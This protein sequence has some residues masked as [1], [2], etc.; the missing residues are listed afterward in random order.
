MNHSHLPNDTVIRCGLVNLGGGGWNAG[1]ATI[2][3]H[4]NE[5][6]LHIA[7]IVETHTTMFDNI[8]TLGPEYSVLAR[9]RHM[10]TRDELTRGGVALV[11]A[12][13]DDASC[14]TCVTVRNDLSSEAC[15]WYHVTTTHIGVFIGVV[16]HPPG[17][18]SQCSVLGCT[19]TGCQDD[20]SHQH[21]T[22]VRRVVAL[23]AKHTPNCRIVL[24][25][26]WNACPPNVT[27][28]DVYR[29]D[30][31]RRRWDTLYDLLLSETEGDDDVGDPQFNDD[32][33]S[34]LTVCNAHN[35]D[36]AMHVTRTDS[37]RNRPRY[38]ILDLVL[39][40]PDSADAITDV[41]SHDETVG[42]HWLL[43][44]CIRVECPPTQSPP[45]RPPTQLDPRLKL[46]RTHELS[47]D[48]RKWHLH[49][50]AAYKTTMVTAKWQLYEQYV[51]SS[52]DQMHAPYLTPSICQSIEIVGLAACGL[53]TTVPSLR[54]V[55]S[56]TLTQT[57]LVNLAGDQLQRATAPSLTAQVRKHKRTIKASTAKME[58]LHQT[59]LRDA[60]TLSKIRKYE[61]NI[62]AA[63]VTLRQLYA[64]C[65]LHS[66]FMRNQHSIAANAVLIQ[67]CANRDPKTIAS[68]VSAIVHTPVLH[69]LRRNK[70][71]HMSSAA[72]K[73]Q[74][75]QWGAHLLEVYA[76]PQP[77]TA[78]LIDCSS[79]V[80]P[81]EDELLNGPVTMLE[82]RD[83][84][85][86]L[87]GTSSCYGTPVFALKQLI[88]MSTPYSTAIAN[89]FTAMLD[90]EIPIPPEYMISTITFHL[91]PGCKHLPH[92]PSS[93]RKIGMGTSIARLLQSIL[94][95][96]LLTFIQRTTALHQ[97]QG[98]FVRNNSVQTVQ[99]LL[100][101]II[102][103]CQLR[104]Q[105]LVSLFVDI[106]SAFSSASHI[107]ILNA[108][109]RVGV[110]GKIWRLLRDY[111]KGQHVTTIVG[112]EV[113][114]PILVLCGLA[115]GP[116]V[117]PVLWNV[118]FDS[119]I[120]STVADLVVIPRILTAPAAYCDDFSLLAWGPNMMTDLQQLTTRF[121]QLCTENALTLNTAPGKTEFVVF[122]SPDTSKDA[123]RSQRERATLLLG[124][125]HVGRVPSYKHLGRVL[126]GSGAHQTH[127]HQLMART[128]MVQHAVGRMSGAGMSRSLPCI[129]RLAFLTHIRPIATFS[130]ELWGW[131]TPQYKIENTQL[132]TLDEN[133]MEHTLLMLRAPIQSV[134]TL[135][136]VLP[137]VGTMHVGIIRL[138][139]TILHMPATH[140]CAQHNNALFHLHHDTTTEHLPTS[141]TWWQTVS[142]LLRDMD[143]VEQSPTTGY[144]MQTGVH[145]YDTVCKVMRCK[146]HTP[147]VCSNCK[148]DLHH[149]KA[150]YVYTLHSLH[151]TRRLQQVQDKASLTEVA[152]LLTDPAVTTGPLPFLQLRRSAANVYR[153]HVRAGSHYVLGYDYYHKRACMWC[154]TGTSSIVHLLRDCPHWTQLRTETQD[155]VA[156]EARTMGVMKPSPPGASSADDAHN[157]YLFTI[158]HAVPT[159]FMDLAVF[160][161]RQPVRD[162]KTQKLLVDKRLS[163]SDH[164]RYNRLLE[165]T[166]G[167]LKTV[168][169]TTQERLGLRRLS[170]TKDL[171][172][173]PQERVL[174]S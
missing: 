53:I 130:I 98:G 96:R 35:N 138:L 167:Y 43:T 42:D 141:R 116:A 72:D 32:G 174:L 50:D 54:R 144:Y 172:P 140:P 91:K 173:H 154:T 126:V 63:V 10:G 143:A 88:Y 33:F 89:H 127:Q 70:P 119:I 113:L 41:H 55:L 36:E 11:V 68:A 169:R 51:A 40:T 56:K 67:A 78:P 157:W 165:M 49:K 26:D 6:S 166:S 82:L 77:Q 92:A 104:R 160:Q 23:L 171:K 38:T 123:R 59:R 45:H 95:N 148:A 61:V 132:N 47:L 75:M 69:Q 44:W 153:C 86:R 48:R 128:K 112:K 58:A 37:S 64:E 30:P 80:A 31:A 135:L 5:H 100:H 117:N 97:C 57:Q 105:H 73:D 17:G 85:S 28:D 115:E 124:D 146:A 21:L 20:H 12:N 108:L 71:P 121:H 134:I 14:I 18:A 162:L 164:G 84:A 27:G 76:R 170:A 107:G 46:Q 147:A 34:P 136:G 90:G 156:Q 62:T 66:R 65:R 137:L 120:C 139:I 25:G 79:G 60:T 13:T 99:F 19:D 161:S 125:Q 102:E 93:Y 122:P 9:Q 155:R 15:T 109:A 103:E 16:Y 110:R 94:S 22:E 2:I 151:H 81:H 142:E 114:F 159:S 111:L 24:A 131:Q 83:C 1:S 106:K 150:H 52:L 133:T 152:D 29:S 158:G 3:E 8:D 118:F 149:L 39:A 7:C 4:M 129:A 74:V 145:W 87:N 101:S 168:L 163:P